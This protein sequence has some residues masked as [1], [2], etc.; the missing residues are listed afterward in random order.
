MF[1]L[2]EH[3]RQNDHDWIK[4]LN[5]IR[6]G[7]QDETALSR[8]NELVRR[9]VPPNTHGACHLRRNAQ[10]FNEKHLAK[11][12]VARFAIAQSN[13]GEYTSCLKDIRQQLLD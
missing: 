6:L 13:V 7:K 5:C 4:L 8:I 12:Q 2:T 1:E 3:M 9:T 10:K 11:V